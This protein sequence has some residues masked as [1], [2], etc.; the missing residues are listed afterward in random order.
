MILEHQ[1]QTVFRQWL[2]YLTSDWAFPVSDSEQKFRREHVLGITL[3]VILIRAYQ[4]PWST[5]LLEKALVIYGARGF[6]T[7]LTRPLFWCIS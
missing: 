5:A 3:S 4:P 1:E 7:V 6:I 2:Q